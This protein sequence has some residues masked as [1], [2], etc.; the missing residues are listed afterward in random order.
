[1]SH[2][3]FYRAMYLKMS[4]GT[5]IPM[6]EMG[7]NNVWEA[8]NR[9]RA[10]DWSSCRWM[11][12]S[13]DKLKLISLTEQDIVAAAQSD[14]DSTVDS[15]EGD[16]N[17]SGTKYTREEI[18]DNLAS[19]NCVQ[20]YGHPRWSSAKTFMNFIKSGFRNAVTMKELEEHGCRITLGHY[21]KDGKYL[22]EYLGDEETL[23]KRWNEYLQEGI[24]PWI[25]LPEHDA[26]RLWTMIKNKNRKPK[27]EKKEMNE[28]FIVTFRLWGSERYLVR[29]TSRNLH[30]NAR[31]EYAYKYANRK[32]AEKTA[33]SIVKRF[34]NVTD[35]RVE[36][37][38]KL[39]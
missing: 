37:I 31:K 10:R 7:D 16:A 20:I 22:K 12:E 18:L 2:T 6:I 19:F 11:H 29:L 36:R 28:Y 38:T 3:I 32:T 14:I 5:Y 26:E 30:H 13:A 39:M 35:A 24:T 4:D 9:R 21:G 15:W 17:A 33:G 25:N 34:Q 1:M 27:P 8:G 23:I